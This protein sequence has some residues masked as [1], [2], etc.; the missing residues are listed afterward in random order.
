[1]MHS[2]QS[3][4]HVICGNS[5]LKF[6]E[7][8]ASFNVKALSKFCVEIVSSSKELNKFEVMTGIVKLWNVEII[9]DAKGNQNV[10]V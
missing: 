9:A 7:A 10:M 3:S 1:M 5:S 6:V 2:F 8:Y 4:Q